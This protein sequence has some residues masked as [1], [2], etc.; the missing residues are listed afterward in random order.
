MTERKIR[1]LNAPFREFGLT[2]H[3]ATKF[4]WMHTTE[5]HFLVEGALEESRTEGGLI[6]GM[7]RTFTKHSYAEVFGPRWILAHWQPPIHR[8]RWV[9]MFGDTAPWPKD[10]EYH[11]IDSVV[12][13]PGLEPLDI[14]TEVACMAIRLHLK[15]T[16]QDLQD[17]FDKTIAQ[18]KKDMSREVYD[19]MVDSENAFFN[20]KPSA[21]GGHVSFGGIDTSQGA[22]RVQ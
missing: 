16:R 12:M 4:R 5:M 1:K 11:P 20:P 7:Q 18:E 17:R 2:P 19:E 10:G 22:N 9:A 15:T 13:P 6:V 14:H 21:R 3:G 8:E